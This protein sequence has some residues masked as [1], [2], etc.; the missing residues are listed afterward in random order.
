MEQYEIPPRS[1]VA[2]IKKILRHHPPEHIFIR[3]VGSIGAGN[4]EGKGGRTVLDENLSDK[5]LTIRETF[6]GLEVFIDGKNKFIFEFRVATPPIGKP[7]WVWGKKW[8]IAYERIKPNG[9]M[10]FACSG[11]PNLQEPYTGPD[12]IRLPE[13]RKTLL[14]SA[15]LTHLIEITF[16]GK[17]P[18][19]KSHPFEPHPWDK[20]NGFYYWTYDDEHARHPA[21]KP[22]NKS[23][24]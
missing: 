22:K 1:C 4:I 3:W 5:T 20:K 11:Y 10:H 7:A 21:S 18:I 9:V 17:I 16:T 24:K 13:A 2:V 19:R 12:D 6:S 15:N 23:R 8:C 14:R